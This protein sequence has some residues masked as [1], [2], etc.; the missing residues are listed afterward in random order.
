M[1]T[2]DGEEGRKGGRVAGLVRGFCSPPIAEVHGDSIDVKSDHLVTYLSESCNHG[3][4]AQFKQSKGLSE[5]LEPNGMEESAAKHVSQDENNDHT[6]ILEESTNDGHKRNNL[7]KQKMSIKSPPSPSL[8]RNRRSFD[9]PQKGN[10]QSF[11]NTRKPQGSPPPS[12]KP[13]EPDK[14]KCSDDHET[15]SSASSNVAS[16]RASRT[17]TTVP[18][19]PIFRCGERA[20]KRK[21][22]NAK[23]EEKNRA[24][25]AKRIEEEARCREE[26]EAFIKQLR[27]T[28]VYRA[29]PVPSF[30]HEPPPPK[31]ELK[32]PPPT[33][34][35]SPKFTQRRSCKDPSNQLGPGDHEAAC[36]NRLNRAGLC[37][38]NHKAENG[39]LR[40][41]LKIR[42]PACKDKEVVKSLR[43][44]VKATTP[45]KIIAERGDD[46][47]VQ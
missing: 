37:N 3:T 21:E 34:A 17:K 19:A 18:S 24:L 46:I 10:E 25:E 6:L 41:T 47:I 36:C 7:P 5:V 1:A 16:S 11:D 2:E 43:G 22:F 14:S 4:V 15:C 40:S 9:K 42:K 30:Y 29:S 20:E 35:T 12:K 38:C 26:Q 8:S 27:K 28:M 33:R 39:K 31:V 45:I 23:V 13:L 44:T 32:K